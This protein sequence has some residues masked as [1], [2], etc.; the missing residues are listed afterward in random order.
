MH[1]D[2]ESG[3]LRTAL[4]WMHSSELTIRGT[5]QMNVEKKKERKKKKTGHNVSHYQIE[6]AEDEVLVKNFFSFM[7]K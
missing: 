1:P 4:E 2:A 5:R 6:S 3:T 7:M